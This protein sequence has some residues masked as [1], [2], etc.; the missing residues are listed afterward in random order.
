MNGSSASAVFVLAHHDLYGDIRTGQSRI[1]D[2]LN[3]SNT[4]FIRLDNMR[5]HRPRIA[6]PQYELSGS[7]VVKERIHAVLLSDEDR[8]GES[9]V[10]FA[11]RE[12]K[13]RAAVATLPTMVVEGR[14]H[15]K[16]VH[17]PQSFLTLESAMFFPV[18]DAVLWR[19]TDG[20]EPWRSPVALVNTRLLTS[21]SFDHVERNLPGAV[22]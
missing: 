11:A 17:D 21:L 4:R 10:F 9:K 3:D 15:S 13:T 12:R 6:A 1:L 20:S 7:V 16:S 19:D 5:V 22:R 18:T 8:P 2:V 14:V